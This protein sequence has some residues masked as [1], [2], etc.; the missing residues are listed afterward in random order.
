MDKTLLILCALAVWRITHLL[1]KED[2]PFDIIYL[3][4]KQLGQGFFGNL[5][6][7]FYCLSIW[8][9]LP[10]GFWMGATWA[11]KIICW[12]ALSGIACLLEKFSDQRNNNRPPVYFEDEKK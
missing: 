6:D 9:A 1:S 2:G 7:C 11:E 5:L 10:V 3:L 8:I 4:R 12:F